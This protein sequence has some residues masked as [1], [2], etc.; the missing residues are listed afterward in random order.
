MFYFLIVNYLHDKILSA[1][2][3]IHIIE[4]LCT[5]SPQ[6]GLFNRDILFVRKKRHVR[7]RSAFS[8]YQVLV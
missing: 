6:R 8:S 4:I 5:V 7:V 2:R 1:Q 3:S